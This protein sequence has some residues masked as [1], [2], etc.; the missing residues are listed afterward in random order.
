MAENT[1]SLTISANSVFS[2]RQEQIHKKGFDMLKA[3]TSGI[4][5][6]AKLKIAGRSYGN[7]VLDLNYYDKLDRHYFRSKEFIIRALIEN[8]IPTLRAISR[9][10]Y[11]TNGIYQ[12]VINY[13]ATIYRYDWYMVPELI[14]DNY[15]EEKVVK[16]FQLTLNRFDATHIKKL[17]GEF[18][19][20]V[21]RDG[22]YYGYLY[23]GENGFLVQELPWRYCRSR[24][25]IAGN[26]AI[27]FDMRFF[28]TKFPDIG[29]R[30]KVLDLFPPEFKEG[31]LL[32][33]QGKLPVDDLTIVES[34]S[35]AATITGSSVKAKGHW[36]LLNPACAFKCQI[37]GN[38]GIPLFVNAI[39]A[40][41]DL[42][43]TQGIDRQRQ[44]QKLLKIIVQK[45]PIDK[46]GDLIFDVDEARDIHNNAVEML[47][48]A[49]GVDVLTTFADI[50]GIDVSE[51]NATVTDDSLNN[52]ERTAY[53]ALG[54]S[55]N[56]F[57][58]EGNLA[59]EK[60]ILADEG[61]L[62]DLI[63][64]FEVLFDTI[65]QKQSTNKKKWNFRF[66][67]LHTTQNNYQALAKL[68][69]EQ[70]QLG[71]SK[72][73][74]QIALGQSQS[75]ILNTVL[76]ENEVLHL[77]EI[78]IPPM[79]SST[80]NAE[81]LTQL[82]SGKVKTAEQQNAT[83]QNSGKTNQTNTNESQEN[84]GRPSK[85]GDQLSEKTIKNKESM[86]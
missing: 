80:M 13:F 40:L 11:K 22:V 52:A 1:Q 3:P 63:L 60:S 82:G 74:P 51:A 38:G 76:F 4:D 83:Q 84:I 43:T 36:Y 18:A 78:M 54:V 85:S 28:D 15:K 79:M 73:L 45:L 10:Y 56:I 20:A 30:M 58:T 68:Y 81:S 57:N 2:N 75:F 49:I 50:Q 7:A 33:K 69:K 26:P 37:T 25:K 31:Y 32:Y 35:A 9:Y 67:M 86:N 34:P 55:R 19:L 47:Q 53:N 70:T 21:I 72:M 17:C 27:E 44:L 5:S 41:I 64:Q 23:E 29:Y 14:S 61:S 39:P 12:K 71:F 59:L 24:Y 42:D 77:S 65:A 6:Y 62:R 66:Y 16:E 46:N 8:D 48:N